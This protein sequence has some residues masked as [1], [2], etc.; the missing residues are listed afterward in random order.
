MPEPLIK[1]QLDRHRLLPYLIPFAWILFL[2]F[3]I[4]DYPL[5]ILFLTLVFLIFFPHL[6]IYCWGC[7]KWENPDLEAFC[8]KAG[9][10]SCGIY[11][12]NLPG[13]APTAA[14]CGWIPQARYLLITQQMIDR[15]P[16]E[17]LQA[18]VAHEIGHQKC[19]HLYFI[20]LLYLGMLAPI[21]LSAFGTIHEIILPLIW[22]AGFYFAIVRPFFEAFEKEADLYVLKLGIPISLMINALRLTG[23]KSLTT[24]I[25]F[26]KEVEIDP[27][28]A[29]QYKRRVHFFQILYTICLFFGGLLWWI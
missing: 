19:G 5:T 8:K 4:P 15:F 7:K 27:E 3:L 9:F 20:P 12:W 25:D 2:Y 17:E 26:L 29:L 24:R 16:K 13:Y 1:S 28:K 11:S 18:V 23:A 10:R 21:S 14:L 6:L 22:I